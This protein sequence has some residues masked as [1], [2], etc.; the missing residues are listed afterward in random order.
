MNLT[1][2]TADIP[3]VKI[4]DIVVKH[5]SIEQEIRNGTKTYK[6]INLYQLPKVFEGFLWAMKEKTMIAIRGDNLDFQIVI[7]NGSLPKYLCNMQ[8]IREFTL[9]GGVR[10]FGMQQKRTEESIRLTKTINN[11]EAKITLNA[12]I[13]V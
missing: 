3:S 12:K 5:L 13:I 10:G 1:L 11:T 7:M 6:Y 2:E 8:A 4:Q 9:L